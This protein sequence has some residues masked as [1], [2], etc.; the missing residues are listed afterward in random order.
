VALVTLGGSLLEM[1][2]DDSYYVV[3]VVESASCCPV[4]LLVVMIC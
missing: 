1:L 4:S 2:N 3:K